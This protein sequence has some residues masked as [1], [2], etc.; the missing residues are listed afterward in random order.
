MLVSFTSFALIPVAGCSVADDDVDTIRAW[1]A[2][3]APNN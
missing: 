2:S 3:G 1:I